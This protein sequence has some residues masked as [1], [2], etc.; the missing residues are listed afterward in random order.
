M[1]TQLLI[2]SL[3]LDNISDDDFYSINANVINNDS[4]HDATEAV[5]GSFRYTKHS[6][7][8]YQ[9]D[10]NPDN[11]YYNDITTSCKYST[12]QQYN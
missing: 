12:H 6:M 9:T 11:N 1:I 8:N 3:P 4:H 7:C 5:Y 2:M 10:V